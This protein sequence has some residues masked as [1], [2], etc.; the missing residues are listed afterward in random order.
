MRLGVDQTIRIPVEYVTI[1]TGITERG[2]EVTSVE[3][4]GYEKI[5]EVVGLLEELG[6]NKD[7]LEINSGEVSGRWY[8][9][10]TFTFN[11]SIE[12]DLK[13]LD[14]IDTFR[15][16]LTDAGATSFRVSSFNNS[17]EDSILDAA[18]RDAINKAKRKSERLIANQS[19][20]VGKILNLHENVKEVIETEAAL[21]SAE[22]PPIKLRGYAGLE[23]VD[24]LF[25]KEFYSKKIEFTIEFA[26]GDK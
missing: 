21:Y 1:S 26:L 18:Y 16:A 10:E 7:Q 9:E 5:A 20:E 15:R 4:N 24:P 13:D 22:P 11:S 14:K 25:N 23:K 8:D 6:F 19:A 17:K 12:F 2:S 3:Q